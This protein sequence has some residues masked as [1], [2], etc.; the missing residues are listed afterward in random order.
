MTHNVSQSLATLK[1]NAFKEKMKPG[2][3]GILVCVTLIQA[4]STGRSHTPRTYKFILKAQRL[5]NFQAS[6]PDEL[7]VPQVLAFLL[8]KCVN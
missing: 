5:V 1:A 6:L 8:W 3:T 2:S 7:R 4:E